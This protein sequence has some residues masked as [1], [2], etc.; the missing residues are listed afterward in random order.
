MTNMGMGLN[1]I[2]NSSFY[3]LIEVLNSKETDIISDP[4]DIFK[5]YHN[6]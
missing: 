4:L 6:G 2:E 1:E 5:S 3:D